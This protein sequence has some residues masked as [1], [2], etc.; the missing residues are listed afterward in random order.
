MDLSSHIGRLRR[1]E[2]EPVREAGAE[3]FAFAEPAQPEEPSLSVAERISS[4]ET[5]QLGA[6]AY[7]RDGRFAAEDDVV[8][9]IA[10][11]VAV[12]EGKSRRFPPAQ[13]VRV[14]AHLV[15]DLHQPLH[16]GTGY[17]DV[18]NPAAPRLVTAPVAPAGLRRA[19]A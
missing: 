19:P 3:Q 16:V 9:Q 13:A 2:T 4:L 7:A 14:L 6:A 17:F 18:R 15:G 10:A 5:L 12:L 1:T 8:H 11:A